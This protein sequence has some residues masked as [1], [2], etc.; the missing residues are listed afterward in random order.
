MNRN[1][2][3]LRA[4][5]MEPGAVEVWRVFHN[6]VE[7]RLKP[8][9]GDLS[10]VSATVN[11]VNENAARLAAVLTLIETEPDP[12]PRSPSSPLL[13]LE[14]WQPR[15]LPKITA[16]TMERAT[17]IIEWHIGEVLRHQRDALVGDDLK[18][19]ASLLG[20]MQKQAEKGEVLF[21]VRELQQF[22]PNATR[23][24]DDLDL[25]LAVL[26]EHGWVKETRK[27]PRTVVFYHRGKNTT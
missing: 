8:E 27:R 21:V 15:K 25:A 7:A 20:Y 10:S 4:L 19:A 9:E 22:G 18:R 17:R 26:K 1:E 2:L 13:F 6:A 5:V 14:E 24:R 11:K 23:G 3:K 16:G 12:V